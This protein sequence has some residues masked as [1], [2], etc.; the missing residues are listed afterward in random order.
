MIPSTL[1]TVKGEEFNRTPSVSAQNS[2]N[3]THQVR[4]TT[5][6]KAE[7]G[8]YLSGEYKQIPLGRHCT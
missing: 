3:I 4:E 8:V 2:E 5:V 7:M 6:L 1:Y